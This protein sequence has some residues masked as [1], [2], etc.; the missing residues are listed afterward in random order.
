MIPSTVTDPRLTACPVVNLRA[1]QAFVV[2]AETLSF[3]GAARKLAVSSS[4]VTK[5]VKSL[6]SDLR[7]TLLHRTTRQV[8]LT[9]AGEHVLGPARELLA[10]HQALLESLRRPVPA[11]RG[12]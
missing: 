11:S 12:W 1:V 6:E 7:S 4:T 5:L 2:V 9:P 3:R 8:A 10:Q